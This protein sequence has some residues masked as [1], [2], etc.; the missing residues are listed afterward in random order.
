VNFTDRRRLGLLA[1]AAAATVLLSTSPVWGSYIGRRIDW[2]QVQRVEVSGT[3]LLTPQEVLIASGVTPGQHLLDEAAVWERALLAHPVIEE[4]RISRRPPGTL[5]IQIVEKR[6]I[7]LI[8]DETLRLA[9]AAGEILPVDPFVV[10]LDLPIVH[11]TL[12]DSA[13]AG[14]TLR[15]LAATARLDTLAPA[16]MAKVSE[17]RMTND[18]SEVLVLS[19]EIADILLPLDVPAGRLEELRRVLLDVQ[20]RFPTDP[21]SSRSPRHRIDMRFE[22]QVVVR[23]SPSAERS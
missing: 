19:H 4:A 18:R 10:P 8:S 5:R 16:L 9:T 13:R 2:L 14:P 20:G 6:P 17:V 23:P 12:T 1:G 15:T 3:R 11:G 22:E 7:A 21:A